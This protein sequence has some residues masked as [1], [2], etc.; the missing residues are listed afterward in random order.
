M[1]AFGNPLAVLTFFAALGC[2]LMAG[3]FFTF[4][5][6]V[7]RALA[8]LPP[9]RGIAAMQAINKS[10]LNPLFLGVFS[11][12]GVACL[13][14]LLL[15]IVRRHDPGALWLLAGSV[16]YLAGVVLVTVVFN[17]PR[18]NALAA[19]DPASDDGV[20]T[21]RRYLTEWTAWNHVRTVTALAATASLILA[22]CQLRSAP[23]P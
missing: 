17:V 2:A 22:F 5:N 16:L 1:T 7:M 12:T 13:I 15:A 11:G 8:G 23:P 3:L 14:G 19:V 9:D 21:W 4:S 6:F 20:R 10:V 18:N